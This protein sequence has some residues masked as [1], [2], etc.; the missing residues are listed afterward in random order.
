MLVLI[1]IVGWLACGILAVLAFM[2]GYSNLFRDDKGERSGL[3]SLIA[4]VT[5][6]AATF[7][8]LAIYG[9]GENIKK[10]MERAA[11]DQMIEDLRRAAKGY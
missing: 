1:Q 9:T 8:A 10:E 2:I 7:G 11:T 6:L 4:L 3:V 5:F